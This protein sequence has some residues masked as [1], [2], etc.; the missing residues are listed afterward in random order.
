ME[1]S[2]FKTESVRDKFRTY[3]NGILSRFP[4]GQRFVKTTYGKTFIL[5]AGEKSNLPLSFCTVLAAT[6]HSGS[7]RLWPYPRITWFMPLTL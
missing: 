1:N 7:L 3:Y 4:F 5:T 6:V 2:V